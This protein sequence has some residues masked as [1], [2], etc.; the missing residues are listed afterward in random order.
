M[1]TRDLVASAGGNTVDSPILRRLQVDLRER[2][3]LVDLVEE[4]ERIMIMA[5]P[6]TIQ[7][8]FTLKMKR[9]WRKRRGMELKEP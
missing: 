1:K 3:P 9:F 5:C 7:A 4:S 2:S 6:G 8:L